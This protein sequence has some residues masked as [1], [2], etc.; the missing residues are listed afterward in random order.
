VNG[1]EAQPVTD[2]PLDVGTFRMSPTGDRLVVSLSVYLDCQDL[3]CTADR[4]SA[5]DDDKVTAQR[6]DQLFR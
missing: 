6:Y 2:L 1:G 5:K 4:N 3:A